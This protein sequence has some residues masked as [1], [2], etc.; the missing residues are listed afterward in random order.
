MIMAQNYLQSSGPLD[1]GCAS[2][3]S[4]KV[5]HSLRVWEVLVPFPLS[6]TKDFKLVVEAPLSNDWNIKGSSTQ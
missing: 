4:L 2:T 6:Q 5:E 1:Q 3:G